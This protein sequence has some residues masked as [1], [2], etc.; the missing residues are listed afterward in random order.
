MELS[1]KEKVKMLGFD[2]LSKNDAYKMYINNEYDKMFNNTSVRIKEPK[3]KK[4]LNKDTEKYKVVLRYINKMLKEMDKEEV[5]DIC[6][7]KNIDRRELVK[8]DGNKVV[9][10][11]LNDILGVFNKK[12][13]DYYRRNKKKHYFF[14][15]L[16]FIVKIIGYRFVNKEKSNSKEGKWMEYSI[17]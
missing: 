7:F 3:L 8:I 15:L 17:I 5:D 10:D 2:N 12:D 4:K 11:S 14:S 13:I 9:D 16:K 6:M 1:T